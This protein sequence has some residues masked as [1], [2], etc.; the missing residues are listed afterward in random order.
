MNSS[1]RA[2]LGRTR[3]GH[4]ALELAHQPVAQLP[5][6]Q[7]CAVL[8]GEGRIV[9]TEHH[10]E[11][12]L[13]HRQRRQGDGLLRVGDGVAD[14]HLVQPNHGAD[15]AGGQLR[16]L[17]AAEAV[18]LQHLHHRVVDALAVALEQG[19]ALAL[20]DLAGH[21]AADAD[22]ADVLAVV[23]VADQHLERGV[24]VALGA[25]DVLEDLVGERPQ[26]LG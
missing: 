13:V 2:S 26:V 24:G 16:H 23:D 10:V 11:R 20:A 7:R 21:D 4:V 6:R 17:A 15:V 18:E 22:A 19:H 8:A 25:G 5:A 14:V 9:D 3:K 12:R 1:A